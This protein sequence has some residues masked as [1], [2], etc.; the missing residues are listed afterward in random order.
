M[1]NVVCT[2]CGRALSFDNGTNFQVFYVGG[3]PLCGLCYSEHVSGVWVGANQA[4][5]EKLHRFYAGMPMPSD[6]KG[7]I[8]PRCGRVW[9]PQVDSCWDCNINKDC[10]KTYG[11]PKTSG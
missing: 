5:K 1:H 11:V 9:G 3:L 6:S 7:W 4:V 8:C 10:P 2:K